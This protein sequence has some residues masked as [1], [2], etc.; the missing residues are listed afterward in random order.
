MTTWSPPPSRAPDGNAVLAWAR[1]EAAP[2][3]QR[4]EAAGTVP[5]LVAVSVGRHPVVEEQVQR[6][7]AEAPAWGV[8]FAHETLPREADE[9]R[10]RRALRSLTRPRSTA[11]HGVVLLRPLPPELSLARARH[12]IPPR[13]DVEGVHPETRGRAWGGAPWLPPAA[14]AAVLLILDA[15]GVAVAGREVVLVAPETTELA[16]ALPLLLARG[17]AVTHAPPSLPDP[18]AIARRAEIL[19]VEGVG[20]LAVDASWIRPGAFVLDAGVHAASDEG[21][22]P[23]IVGDVDAASIRGTGATVTPVPGALAGALTAAVF[24]NTL[25]AALSPSP[26]QVATALPLFDR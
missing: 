13:Q 21:G 17:A 4:L 26:D 11:P 5:R 6:Y 1:R 12:E 2:L 24:R 14:G 18:A 22:A 9:V 7:A 20:P 16:T 15:A 3:R 25:A 19:L 10:L 23:P 8:S